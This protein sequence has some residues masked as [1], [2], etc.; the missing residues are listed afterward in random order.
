MVGWLGL[1]YM[2]AGRFGLGW[3]N[4]LCLLVFCITILGS[5]LWLIIAGIDD[6]CLALM[7]GCTFLQAITWL[8]NIHWTRLAVPILFL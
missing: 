2:H 1:G 7:L 4:L 6:L 5:V 3:E 8:L